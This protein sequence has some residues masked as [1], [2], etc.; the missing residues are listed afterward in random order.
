M[1]DERNPEAR[2]GQTTPAGESGITPKM[3]IL[4]II[5][6]HR[7]T[8]KIF[9]RLEAELGVCVCCQ[10]LFLTL[11]EAADRYAFDLHRV[12]ADIRAV[13][14]R[15]DAGETDGSEDASGFS[16]DKAPSGK[17]GDEHGEPS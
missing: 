8:E 1:N 9:K 7:E 2:P 17:P 10:G 12:L 15:K 3:T 16:G 14:D 6:E 13:V 4:G 11:R 5:S